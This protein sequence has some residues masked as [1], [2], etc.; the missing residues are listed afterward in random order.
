MPVRTDSEIRR[1]RGAEAALRDRA[2]LRTRS[3]SIPGFRGHP[4]LTTD[5]YPA[6]HA[7]RVH[8]PLDFERMNA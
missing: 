4:A 2:G 5:P 8:S 3:G 1:L 6:P 7:D